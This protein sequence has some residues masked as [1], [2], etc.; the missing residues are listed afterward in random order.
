MQY[1]ETLFFRAELYE[2]SWNTF[3]KALIFLYF[4]LTP[5]LNLSPTTFGRLFATGRGKIQEIIDLYTCSAQAYCCGW[6]QEQTNQMLS[7]DQ[8]F[9]FILCWTKK[10][11]QCFPADLTCLTLFRKT[12]CLGAGA[13]T[14]SINSENSS[15]QQFQQ[16]SGEDVSPPKIPH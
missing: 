2:K 15:T 10:K 9:I 11:N 4:F 7:F 5:T 12:D 14:C 1:S 3:I 13:N 16:H 8:V 6:C